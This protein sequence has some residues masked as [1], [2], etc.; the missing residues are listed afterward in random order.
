MPIWPFGKEAVVMLTGPA[1][2][3]MLS[4]WVAERE[5]LSTTLTVKFAVL[6]LVGV[7]V[8]CAADKLN[9]WGRAPA[10]IDHV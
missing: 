5:F 2:T 6:A 8:I 1:D 4:A 9:P 10:V 7:P 3:L